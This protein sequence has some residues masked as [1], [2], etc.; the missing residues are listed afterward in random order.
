VEGR[1]SFDCTNHNAFLQLRDGALSGKTGFTAKAGYCYVGALRRDDHFLIVA[2]LACG[3][4]GN[5]GYKWIDT[6]KLM[7]YGLEEF[8]RVDLAELADGSGQ[9]Q[10][11]VL[12]GRADAASVEVMRPEHYYVLM[13]KAEKAEYAL[14][15]LPVLA[16]PVA[17]NTVVGTLRC[18][19]GAD[20]LAAWPVVANETVDALDYKD[21]VS[22][23][24]GW[25]LR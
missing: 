18:R 1:R 7:N 16:A 4:P 6:R 21:C 14:Q 5:K 20:V 13:N 24:A 8:E 22:Y 3:W 17:Q 11:R 9:Q 12:Q 19:I 25:F 10:I 2:L 15:L 23:V